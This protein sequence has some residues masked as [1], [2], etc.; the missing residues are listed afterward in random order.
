MTT[1]TSLNPAPSAALD[2]SSNQSVYLTEAGYET[3][4]QIAFTQPAWQWDLIAV[5]YT[6]P[7]GCMV[8][9]EA[10]VIDSFEDLGECCAASIELNRRDA[11][12]GV[13]Y[14]IC[15]HVPAPESEP[16]EF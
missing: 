14:T 8:R 3:I 12:K 15:R 7:E 16:V 1:I 11:G 6:G 4:R 10:T 2:S 9:G 5:N 13:Y